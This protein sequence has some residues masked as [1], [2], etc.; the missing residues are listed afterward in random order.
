MSK[1]YVHVVG[2]LGNQLFQ[3]AAGYAYAKRWNK[4][5]CID[6]SGWTCGQGRNPNEYALTIFK[7][8]KYENCPSRGVTE[9]NQPRFDYDP[10]PYI[11]GDVQLHGYYQSMKFFEDHSEF[12]DE[13]VLPETRI[14]ENSCAVHIRRGDYIRYSN[15]HMVCNT[16][17]F[18]D[19]IKDI[20][21]DINHVFTDDSQSV[22]REFQ[23]W[24]LLIVQGNDELHDLALMS[25]HDN[26]ICSNSSFSWWASL[27]GVKK[28]KIIVPSRWFNNFESHEDIFREDF[29][30]YEL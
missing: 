23:G 3:I 28:K 25:N 24:E 26:I 30:K 13:L 17:Y 8:F 1:V 27:L 10:I 5:L 2:G 15:V 22:S 7:N 20:N 4:Q 12:L 11:E 19:S 21:C 18:V 14:Y 9:Y 6:T 16:K 29:I